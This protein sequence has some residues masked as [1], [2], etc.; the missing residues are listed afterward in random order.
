[1]Q[2]KCLHHSSDLFSL[3]FSLGQA[4]AVQESAKPADPGLR[5]GRDG[6]WLAPG[7]PVAIVERL[8]FL[9]LWVPY[10][11]IPA[12]PDNVSYACEIY[13]FPRFSVRGLA[14]VVMGSD[15]NILSALCLKINKNS[16]IKP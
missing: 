8:N 13:F 5:R 6:R 7:S 1:M 12:E 4:G 11:A 16:L 2:K 10:L 9:Q 15:P 3:L 14:C